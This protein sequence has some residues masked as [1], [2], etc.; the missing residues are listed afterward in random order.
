MEHIYPAVFETNND[1][2]YTI[3]FPDLPGCISEG[4]NLGD[5]LL[6]GSTCLDAM[7]RISQL[8]G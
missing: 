3:S 5:A 1:G 2:S 7:D 4:K 8:Q 6:Y